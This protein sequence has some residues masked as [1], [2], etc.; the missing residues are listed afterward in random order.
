MKQSKR[1]RAYA[2]GLPPG[3]HRVV[4]FTQYLADMQ[5]VHAVGFWRGVIAVSVLV[6][7]WE[8]LALWLHL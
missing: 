1:T 2:E 7:I 5:R 6:I 4:M 3:Q 8:G